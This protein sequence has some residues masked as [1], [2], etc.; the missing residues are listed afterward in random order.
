MTYEYYDDKFVVCY[1]CGNKKAYV[2]FDTR[3]RMYLISCDNCG[4]REVS[5][6]PES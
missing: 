2:W 5:G 4:V 1:K 6:G 3:L